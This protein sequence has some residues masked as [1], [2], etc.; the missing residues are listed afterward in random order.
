M[1]LQRPGTGS[2]K[3]R[4]KMKRPVIEPPKIR[5]ELP[6][7][8]CGDL[9]LAEIWL[10]DG[11]RYQGLDCMKCLVAWGRILDR[12]TGTWHVLWP[13]APDG[14]RLPREVKA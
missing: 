13:L 10:K 9:V 8:G 11:Y 12:R 2:G 6:C 5:G 4:L 1:K 3:V 14:S 7:P